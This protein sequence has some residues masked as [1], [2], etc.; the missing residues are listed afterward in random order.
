MGD[1][2]TPLAWTRNSTR[3]SHRATEESLLSALGEET[4]TVLRAQPAGAQAHTWGTNWGLLLEG[5]EECI[6]LGSRASPNLP[7]AETGKGL[8]N[9]CAMLG[10][11]SAHMDVGKYS[12][13]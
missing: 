8:C 13:L 7:Q 10:I 3:L 1:R 2:E 11:S 6:T 9:S 12:A 4:E 5:T